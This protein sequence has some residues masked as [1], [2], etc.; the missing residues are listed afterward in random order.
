MGLCELEPNV[1]RGDGH[2]L[3]DQLQK[4]WCAIFCGIAFVVIFFFMEE[5]SFDRSPYMANAA[6]ERRPPVDDMAASSVAAS[7]DDKDAGATHTENSHAS[8]FAADMTPTG[9]FKPTTVTTVDGSASYLKKPYAARLRPIE[10][11]GFRR[12]NKML[13]LMYRP[14]Q[15]LTF[16]IIA[17]AGFLYGANIIWLSVLNATEAMVLSED[18]YNMSTSMIGVTFIAPLVGTTLA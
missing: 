2:N 13:R 1:L 14:F 4:Y 16:P 5:T 3:T 11:E 18:P 17:Y 15:L 12:K 9:L 6:E 8:T 7:K 10:G